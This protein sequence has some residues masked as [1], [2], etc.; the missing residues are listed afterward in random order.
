MVKASGAVS[1]LRARAVA[2][3]R[4]G[5]E[6]SPTARGAQRA[7]DIFA[8]FARERRPLSI[9]ELARTLSIPTSTCHGLVKTLE[10]CGYLAEIKRAR[11]YYPTSL[12]LRFASEIARYDPIPAFL[13]PMLADIREE[14]GETV[15][16]GK[17]ARNKAV[18]LEVLESS[19]G[20][21][22]IAKVGDVRPFHATAIGKALLSTMSEEER[23]RVVSQISYEPL[24]ART[25]TSAEKL[26]KSVEEGR[27]RG[28]YLCDGE[29]YIDICAIG[30]PIDVH[31]DQYCVI[32]SGPRDRIHRNLERI[33][34]VLKR[35]KHRVES[36]MR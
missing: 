21:R 29:Y 22:Y 35:V 15:V 18:Y 5:S 17:R 19:E 9:S 3:A 32:V 31:G 34:Q 1:K 4:S 20:L 28:W 36:G 16:L 14:T 6:G 24:T 7:L 27:Q 10:H 11:G 25:L 30:V 33:G 26:L 8:T 12:L 23:L 13:G 2:P